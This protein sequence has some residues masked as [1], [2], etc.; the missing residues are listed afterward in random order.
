MSKSAKKRS[1]SKS[2]SSAPSAKP[3]K[4]TAGDTMPENVNSGSKQSRVIAMLQSPAG[5]TIAAVMKATGWQP[6]SVRGFLA[7]VVRRRLKLELGSR[8]RWMAIGSTRSQSEMLARLFLRAEYHAA[9]KDRSGAAGS[10]SNST[11]RLRAYVISTSASFATVGTQFSGDR[12]PL[13]CLATCCF[14]SWPTGFRP[15][16]SGIWTVRASACSTTRARLEKAWT[17]RRGLS[18]GVSRTCGPAPCSA[19]NGTG[20]CSG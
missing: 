10:R 7:G 11:S 14:G 8:R 3:S 1:P 5:A 2:A 12:R 6:H 19:V 4:R 9:G 13:T 15:I 16:V 18:F 17:E 20:E